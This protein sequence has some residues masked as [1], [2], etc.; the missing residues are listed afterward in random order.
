[1]K[2]LRLKAKTDLYFLAKTILGYDKLSPDLHGHFASWIKKTQ[3]HQYRMLLLPRGHYK[4]TIATIADSI[5]V[6]LPD[7]SNNQPYPRNLGPNGRLLV[8]HESGEQASRFLFSIT[9]HFKRNPLMLALF[10]ECVPG[11]NQRQN[12]SELE[13]PRSSIWSEPTIDTMG[14]GTKGQGRHYNYIKCDDIYGV[15]ARDSEAV[16]KAAIAWL[17]N[18]Q[19]FLL[20]PKTDHIDFI[21]TRYKHEDAYSYI[22]EVY[23][24]RLTKYVRPVEEYNKEAGKKLPIFPAE[25][26]EE[27][28]AI[29]KK[30]PL[31]Y[32]A[33]YLNDP[34][35]GESEFNQDWERYYKKLGSWNGSD[36]NLEYEDSDDRLKKLSWLDL[37]RLVF[38]DP[39]TTGNSG[40]VVTGTNSDRNPKVFILDTDQSVYD[41][42]KLVR[43]IFELNAKWAPRAIIIE[44]VLFSQLFRH[45]ISREQEVKKEY[46][47]IIPAKTKGRSKEDRVR[48]LATWM[49]NGQIIMHESQVE[50]I[51]QVRKFPG[52]REYHTLDA[53]AY[54]PEFWRAS[55]GSDVEDRRESALAMLRKRVNP[56]T[57]YSK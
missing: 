12:K 38:I 52:I 7:D 21:G 20:T 16:H 24:D 2:L 19:A 22:M 45:W 14:V 53:L 48:G 15:D 43:K 27:A 39:A 37:D 40:I 44:E 49:A 33:Q 23:R 51:D 26:D 57:G 30:S 47:K 56:M 29:L 9:E 54:G 28:L 5:Q 11:K 46:F 50:F 32:N 17:S 41:P 25:F 10:P 35:S 36:R 4:S 8:V 6:V 31:V 13:L 1:M 18:L 34:L 42:P 3:E 55:V